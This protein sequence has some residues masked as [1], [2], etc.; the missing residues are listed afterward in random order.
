M[1]LA[2]SPGQVAI[3]PSGFY[4]PWLW[5]IAL[6]ITKA[7]PRPLLRRFAGLLAEAYHLLNRRRR[8]IV[9]ENVLPALRNDREAARRIARRLYQQFALKLV[10]LWD[11]ENGVMP[12][13]EPVH[14]NV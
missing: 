12:E 9:I 6:K 8:E 13:A 10:D 11:Y 5:R 7:A 3:A 4:R 14:E 2:K 1:G